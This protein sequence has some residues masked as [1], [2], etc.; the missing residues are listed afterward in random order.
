MQLFSSIQW[1]KDAWEHWKKRALQI[2]A[3]ISVSLRTVSTRLPTMT[4]QQIK[5][6][7]PEA[8][9]KAQPARPQRKAA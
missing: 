3:L 1:Q 6:V 2:F 7:T 4:N 5:D 8:W 9:A